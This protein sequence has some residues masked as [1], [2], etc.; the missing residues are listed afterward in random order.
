MSISE[1]A[2]NYEN[3]SVVPDASS[4]PYRFKLSVAEGILLTQ[5]AEMNGKFDV[6]K[7]P[8]EDKDTETCL[9]NLIKYNLVRLRG[10]YA[11]VTPA[12]EQSIDRRIALVY[13]FGK[14]MTIEGYNKSLLT[15]TPKAQNAFIGALATVWP[16][17]FNASITRRRLDALFQQFVATG[18]FKRLSQSVNLNLYNT[19]RGTMAYYTNKVIEANEATD[20]TYAF[21]AEQIEYWT[22]IIDQALVNNFEGR[23]SFVPKQAINQD[24]YEILGLYTDENNIK[25]KFKDVFTGNTRNASIDDLTI[26]SKRE[27]LRQL[28]EQ[29]S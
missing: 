7:I 29:Q 24:H 26:T 10:L 3:K 12:G 5:I 25:V 18:V 2:Q 8:D 27:V 16:S 23:D 28:E 20:H 21:I 15:Q 13:P 19:L 17:Y 1:Q 6:T 22:A 14:D 9:A 4:T 11:E